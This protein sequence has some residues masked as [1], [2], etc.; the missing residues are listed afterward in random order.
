MGV[1]HG[2]P[3]PLPPTIAA[4]GAAPAS[5]MDGVSTPLVHVHSLVT[6]HCLTKRH[7]PCILVLL[8]HNAHTR[9]GIG[10]VA[11]R[12]FPAPTAT[13]IPMHSGEGIG[14]RHGG[15]AL[16][17]LYANLSMHSVHDLNQLF[18]LRNSWILPLS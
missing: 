14:R 1:A 4:S 8:P 17:C 2:S 5:S 3:Y 16:S 6:E 9:G 11:R 10:G 18:C 13:P 7:S 12:A 15:L